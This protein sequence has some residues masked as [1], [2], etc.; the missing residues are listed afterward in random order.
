MPSWRG[1]KGS[2]HSGLP[3]PPLLSFICHVCITYISQVVSSPA[4]VFLRGKDW[5]KEP[6]D[7]AQHRSHRRDSITVFSYN[8]KSFYVHCPIDLATLLKYFWRVISIK[9][10]TY[11]IY[12]IQ[13]YIYWMQHYFFS[14]VFTLNIVQ[15]AWENSVLTQIFEMWFI[16]ST[17][18]RLWSYIPQPEKFAFFQISRQNKDQLIPLFSDSWDMTE[19]PIWDFKLEMSGVDDNETVFHKTSIIW[20][21]QRIRPSKWLW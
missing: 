11:I 2:E 12:F 6:P 10:L 17:F 21:L 7:E 18:H 16:K 9:H 14:L 15:I 8:Q 3:Q 19:N 20:N 4:C 5:V 13:Y 1:E